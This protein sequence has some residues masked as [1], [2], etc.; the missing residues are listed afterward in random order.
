MKVR[1][2]LASVILASFAMPVVAGAQD[3]GEGGETTTYSFDDDIVTGDLVRPDGGLINVRRR[4]NRQS[5]IQVRNQFVQ[6][7]L[8][9]VENL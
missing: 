9:S 3:R 2:V 7:M 5:L 8:K 4:G 1:F 6:E